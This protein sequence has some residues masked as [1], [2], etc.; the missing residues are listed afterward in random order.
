[1]SF[2][3]GF[4][5]FLST[6]L[7]K[8]PEQHPL[9]SVTL[10]SYLNR[11]YREEFMAKDSIALLPPTGY[12]S[13]T[14]KICLAWLAWQKKKLGLVDMKHARNSYEIVIRQV[15]VDGYGVDAEGNC[16]VFQF[17]GC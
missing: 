12:T 7:T 10:P 15:A 14:S 2:G 17:H 4:E 9:D 6:A 8:H 5:A 16:Y 11:V 13:K 1:M 3:A